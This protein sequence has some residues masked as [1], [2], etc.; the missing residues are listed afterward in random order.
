M[1]IKLYI[2]GERRAELIK[3]LYRIYYVKELYILED[4]HAIFITAEAPEM[5]ELN[6]LIRMLKKNYADTIKTIKCH[7]VG[8]V[9]KNALP[10]VST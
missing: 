9:I 1:V 2:S 5:S 8:D 6:Y 10:I 3:Y 7:P 4:K